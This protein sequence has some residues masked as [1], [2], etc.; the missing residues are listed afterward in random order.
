MMIEHTFYFNLITS[1]PDND[2]IATVHDLPRHYDAA[3]A[4]CRLLVLSSI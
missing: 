4:L 3:C 2:Y 1:I